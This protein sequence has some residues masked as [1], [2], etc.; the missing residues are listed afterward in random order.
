MCN[1]IGHFAK[2]CPDSNKNDDSGKNDTKTLQSVELPP[3]P[4]ATSSGGAGKSRGDQNSV[5]CYN[6][7]Q[8]GHISTKCPSAALFCKLEQQSPVRQSGVKATSVCRSEQ[9]EG[10]QVNQIV[11]DTGCSRTM[12]RRDLVPGH[13]LIEGDAVTIWCAHGDTVLYPVAQLELQVNGVPVCVEAAVSE[14][15][16]VQILLGTDVPELNQLLGDSIMFDN[17]MM[18]VTRTQAMKQLQEETTTRSKEHESGAK[19]HRISERSE[20]PACIGS[21]FDSEM[22]SSPREKV[23]K[24]R[25]QKGSCVKSI[26]RLASKTWHQNH[27]EYLLQS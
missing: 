13:K 23:H 11:L 18:V 17:C 10:I 8:R 3:Q 27:W 1:Q 14:S 20:E 7:R 5:K 6:C 4:K 22:F 26:M 16:L 12:V 19:P 21:E 2:N 25:R 9:V 15:L 24:T